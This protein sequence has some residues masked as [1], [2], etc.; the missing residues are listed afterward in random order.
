[1]C[2]FERPL[3]A[4]PLSLTLVACASNTTEQSEES[5]IFGMSIEEIIAMQTTE[6]CGV[7]IVEGIGG[8][9]VG[10]T[11]EEEFRIKR[12]CT[13]SVYWYEY[14][15]KGVGKTFVWS[16]DLDK[17]NDNVRHV[18]EEGK[19]RR[20]VS[21]PNTWPGRQTSPVL[22]SYLDEKYKPGATPPAAEDLSQDV[23]SIAGTIWDAI[24][25]FGREYVLY[26]N[27]GGSMRVDS[28]TGTAKN[29][30]W[31]QDGSTVFF[32]INDNFIER[33]GSIVDDMM[34]GNTW[35]KTGARWTWTATRRRQDR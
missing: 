28:A 16:D 8:Y 5:E 11:F 19:I 20:L 26:F 14:K 3:L 1:M 2:R 32:E 24:D 21:G 6:Y 31:K 29:A 12:G 13:N 18:F 25:S 30:T 10:A 4:V 22:V 33:Y 27:D 15:E 9:G 23:D 17:L 35:N 7:D 34:T